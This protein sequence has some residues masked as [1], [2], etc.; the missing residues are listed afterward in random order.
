MRPVSR[1]DLA[2]VALGL[3][4][5]GWLVVRALYGSLPG[6]HWWQPLPLLLL[7][8]AEVLGARSLRARL[9][10]DRERRRAARSG[11]AVAMTPGQRVDEPVEPMLVAR[12]AVL[13]QASAWAG[14][15]FAG[16]W[17]GA[18]VFTGTQVGRLAA[19]PSDALAAGLGVACSLAL[20]V[21]ALLL[22]GACRTPEE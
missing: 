16:L 6:F 1:R 2:V 7:A 13:A 4:V 22:E 19:A 8:V 12:L 11:E 17:G 21:A 18:L 14:A 10:A 9:G 3:S 20:V 15:G 5:V